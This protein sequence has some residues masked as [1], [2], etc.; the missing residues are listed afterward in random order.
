MRITSFVL[1]F[2]LLG[3]SFLWTAEGL[4][5]WAQGYPSTSLVFDFIFIAIAI[6]G[7]VVANKMFPRASSLN[8]IANE[9][10]PTKHTILH[11]LFVGGLVF[12][13]APLVLGVILT[14]LLGQEYGIIASLGIITFPLGL[15]TSIGAGVIL[16][17]KRKT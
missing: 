6:G 9:E 15:I 2:I 17:F 7:M 4:A 13:F 8:L 5:L 16:F 11:T 1:L 3:I 12:A 14:P 10:Q